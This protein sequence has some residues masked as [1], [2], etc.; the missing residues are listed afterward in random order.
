LC[1]LAEK[2]ELDAM[3]AAAQGPATADRL[4]A[5]QIANQLAETNRSS[6]KRLSIDVRAGEVTLR[7]SVGSFHEKQVAIQ[8]CRML[9]GIGRL[10]DAVEVSAAS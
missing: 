2:K 7:G 5:T 9:A 6:L 4:L 3:I 1:Y 10:I 8:A